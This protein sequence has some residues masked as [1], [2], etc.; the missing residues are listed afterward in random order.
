MPISAETVESLRA[1]FAT[2]LPHLD[3]RTTRLLLAA[4]ARSLGH[5]GI[6]AVARAS[7]AAL[8]RV[9]R[10]VNE[11]EAGTAPLQG[12]RKPGAGRKTLVEK[13]PGLVP[14]LLELVEP[15]RRG[16]PASPLSWT[17]L[18]TG[19]LAAELT[20]K[21]HSVG[22]ET[23]AKLL[24]DNGFSLQANAKMLEGGQ[25]PDRDAQFAYL[26]ARAADHLD[27]GQ[28]VISVDTMM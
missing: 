22:A 14:A 20:Q 5:G 27:A 23:V 17:T 7:D 11:L 26:N 2:I 10:G 16:D 3:E 21:G 1:K 24:K 15:T 4:E 6:T 19:K 13:D 12:V 28:P 18:S 8:S 9:Q 25:H